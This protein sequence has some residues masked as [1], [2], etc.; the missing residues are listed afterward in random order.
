MSNTFDYIIIIQNDTSN[1]LTQSFRYCH[2]FTIY[3]MPL[4]KII[5]SMWMNDNTGVLTSHEKI[6]IKTCI[7]E[8]VTCGVHVFPP[9]E[10]NIKR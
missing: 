8:H 3:V 4:K 10:V 7:H 5:C 6:G 1:N 9:K 2:K